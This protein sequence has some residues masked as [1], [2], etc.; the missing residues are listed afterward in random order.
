MT[1]PMLLRIIF[2]SVLTVTIFSFWAGFALLIINPH[3][4]DH[5]SGYTI[6]RICIWEIVA[7]IVSGTV[8]HVW[9]DR[10][11]NISI[12]KSEQ[13][14]KLV[15]NQKFGIY[16]LAYFLIAIAI[17]IWQFWIWQFCFT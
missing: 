9:I 10:W 14:S 2:Q 13:Q 5:L 12:E 8:A 11:G 1:S 7:L 6:G 3:F 16:F 4:H 15:M 17:G